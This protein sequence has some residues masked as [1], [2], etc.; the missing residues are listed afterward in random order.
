MLQEVR[1]ARVLDAIGLHQAGRLSCAEAAEL[2]G[3]SERHFRR[4]RDAYEAGGHGG[5]CGSP[6]W[7]RV[8]PASGRGRDRVGGRGVWHALLR[9]HGQ[10]PPRGDP[11]PRDVGRA[12]VPARL[13]VDEERATAAWPDHEGAEALGTPQEAGAPA[14]ARD[15][16][17]PGWVETCL[18]AAGAGA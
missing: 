18:A 13:H 5:A 10:A 14:A 3:M 16:G 12:T 15:A 6:A 11:R 9:L 2:L 17:V 8:G 4:L 7:A 1:M